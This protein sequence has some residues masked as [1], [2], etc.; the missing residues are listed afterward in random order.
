VAAVSGDVRKA[1]HICRHACDLARLDNA[2]KVT[3]KHIEMAV[4]QLFANPYVAAMQTLSPTA[5]L[6]VLAALQAVEDSGEADVKIDEVTSRATDLSRALGR[7]A[8][9]WSMVEASIATLFDMQLLA[10]RGANGCR[11][12]RC[13]PQVQADDV[14]FALKDD[15]VL[16]RMASTLA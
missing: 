2:D 1:L 11:A 8:A 5:Q 12:D 13:A 10:P 16:G 14:A 9:P 6:L 15:P 4:K 3:L 7:D